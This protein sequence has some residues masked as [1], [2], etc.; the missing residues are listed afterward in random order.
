MVVSDPLSRAYLHSQTTEIPEHDLIHHI[1]STFMLL[2]IGQTHHTQLHQE[3][4]SD[5]VLQQ[6]INFT[7][8][9]WPSKHNIPTVVKPY[10]SLRSEIVYHEGLLLK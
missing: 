7:M 1:S 6:L 3:T 9:G 10:Y 8:N 5:E 4:A 2:P